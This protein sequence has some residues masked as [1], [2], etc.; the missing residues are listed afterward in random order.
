MAS[1]TGEKAME[2]TESLLPATSAVAALGVLV[3][4]R[5]PAAQRI[6]MGC[7][8]LLALA[9]VRLAGGP[10]TATARDGFCFPLA[11]A[12]LL[13][14][15]FAAWNLFGRPGERWPYRVVIYSVYAAAFQLIYIVALLLTPSLD[16]AR[17]IPA[18]VIS[19]AI[20][21]AAS[22]FIVTLKPWFARRM[23]Q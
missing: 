2:L 13:L 9:L 5:Y 7:A 12:A 20:Y 17:V 18:A 4:V 10:T 15:C 19:G 8:L 3:L 21:I 6:L 1:A 14:L 22:L 11:M 16:P 23:L